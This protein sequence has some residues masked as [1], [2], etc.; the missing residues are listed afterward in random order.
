MNK[1]HGKNG[2]PELPTVDRSAFWET[3]PAEQDSIDMQD[4]IDWQ[5]GFT[6][7]TGPADPGTIMW[8]KVCY[9]PNHYAPNFIVLKPGQI[10]LHTCPRCGK[11]VELK[12]TDNAT[13]VT[14]IPTKE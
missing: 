11:S 8:G 9:H 4:V 13:Q 5:R 1:T 14:E 10:H 3:G 7:P 2:I 6:P 12:R